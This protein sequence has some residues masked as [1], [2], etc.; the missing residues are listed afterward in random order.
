MLDEQQLLPH[1]KP[2]QA[3]LLLVGVLALVCIGVY[4]TF[5]PASSSLSVPSTVFSSARAMSHVRQI[6]SHS[7]PTGSLENTK[8]RQ[9][10]VD[11]LKELDLEPEIQSAFV[12]NS[13]K[14]LAGR[15]HNVLVRIPGKKTGKALLLSAHYDSV[16]TGPGAADDGASVAAILEALKAIKM[17][18]ALQNDLICIFTDSEETG[19]LGA[20]A[21][22]RQHPWAKAIGLALNFEYRGNRG[23]FMMFETSQGNGK[24]IEGLATAAPFLL[25]NSLM[26]E[27]YKHLPN[28]T[29][30]SVFKQAGIPGMNFA[31]I[32]G[33][34]SYHTQLDRPEF[35]DQGSLQHEGDIMLA[36]V[37]HFGNIPLNG[38]TSSD[39]VYFDVPGLGLVNYPVGWVF[40]LNVILL[41]LFATVLTLALKTKTVRVGRIVTSAIV[42]P[43][44]LFGL[45]VTSHFLWLAI[46]QLHPEYDS[47]IQGDTYNSHWYLLAF[48]FLNIGLFGFLQAYLCKWLQPIEFAFGIMV[49]WLVLLMVSG[50]WL[51]GA[52]YLFFW[53][54]T[55]MLVVVGGLFVLKNNNEQQLVNES[56][57]KLIPFMVR[58]AHHERTQQKTVRPEPLGYAQESP[59]EGLNQGF[60][61]V[62]LIFL[63][64]IPGLLIF[65]PLIKGLFIGLTPQMIGVVIV[66][67]VLLLG[68]LTPLL[69]M[70]G[71]RN[72]LIRASLLLGFAALVAGSLTSG[73]DVDHPRQN[74]LFYALNSSGQRAFWLS[75]D[76]QLDQWTSV[77]FP[78]GQAKQQVPKIFGD[79]FPAMWAAQAPVL[80]LQKPMI[81]TLED[82]GISDKS[83]EK[84]KIKIRVKS[85]RLAPKLTITIEG[86]AVLQSKVAGQLYSQS[87]QLNWSLDSV[88][89]NDEDLIIEFVVKAGVPFKVRVIDFTYGLPVINP[90]SRPSAM[91]DK[92]S[93]FSDTIAAVSVFNFQ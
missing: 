25:A 89:L 10:L 62:L 60:L 65:T 15:I 48:V 50:V 43:F 45:A 69:A 53:P 44:I 76:N 70:I 86:I 54:L 20:E 73:F 23:A 55:A 88:G 36:L 66:L 42:F 6:G 5:P 93:E 13:Q 85:S 87:P 91:T 77:F 31:A 80:A 78:N 8:V 82:N 1:L 46:R 56:L 58:Q 4:H 22:V 39:R 35:L 38:L 26:Y 81:E 28:D 19:L 52:S 57:N 59:V 51:P 9:Y 72:N 47:F 68:L 41:M 7:H 2:Y 74:T 71:Q 63:G 12:V 61:N 34:T 21:F 67:L 17:Q 84:R 27:V 92:P 79:R 14:K 37:K 83:A 32:E 11:Q 24:L 29:D 30:M 49:C 3:N 40:P 64:S 75:T 16:H 90:I 18:P 33:H